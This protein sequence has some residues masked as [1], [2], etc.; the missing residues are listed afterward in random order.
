MNEPTLQERYDHFRKNAEA[1]VETLKTLVDHHER[2]GDE[3]MASKLRVTA[4]MPWQAALDADKSGDLWPICE[5][6]QLPI[7]DDEDYAA[8]EDCCFHRQCVSQ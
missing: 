2:R 8:S 4:L 7:K 5:V 6:C 1:F 3:D